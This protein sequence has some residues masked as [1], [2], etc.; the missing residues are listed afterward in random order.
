MILNHFLKIV[1]KNWTKVGQNKLIG[2][3]MWA[4][5]WQTYPIDKNV[6]FK[7][8]GANFTDLSH[9]SVMHCVI[10]RIKVTEQREVNSCPFHFRYYVINYAPMVRHPY[11]VSHIRKSP[12]VIFWINL[13]AWKISLFLNT[14]VFAKVVTS[15]FVN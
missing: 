12:T 7:C 15:A 8:M 13:L 2:L 10:T 4:Y 6:L 1:N 9:G 14:D 11:E 5:L 3:Q